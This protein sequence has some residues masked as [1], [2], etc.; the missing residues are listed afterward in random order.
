MF[1]YGLV[2]HLIASI[3]LIVCVETPFYL[4]RSGRISDM[5]KTLG[6]IA[7]VNNRITN[8]KLIVDK[9]KA[10]SEVQSVCAKQTNDATEL[11]SN[12]L[13]VEPEE[14][15]NSKTIVLQII[16]FLLI[17]VNVNAHYNICALMPQSMGT[18]NVYTAACFLSVGEMVAAFISTPLSFGVKRKPL[19]LIILATQVGIS[20]VLCAIAVMGF[21]KNEFSKLLQSILSL[22]FKIIICIISNILY[23]YG[24]EL[25]STKYRANVIALAMLT[26]GAAM[27]LAPFL[28]GL[29]S[30]MNVHPLVTGMPLAV[31]SIVCV[32]YLP[33][34]F[35]AKV[36][37]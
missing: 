27:S 30:D 19:F 32:M 20:L 17:F 3:G 7:K 33:E 24:S 1:L 34:T 36:I 28:S 14:T 4:N 13:E 6:Y 35:D 26:G 5:L 8:H 23:S 12:V 9:Y 15:T 29:A 22:V 31:I 18:D 21:Q 37:N 2:I 10:L 25:F 11:Q 16:A